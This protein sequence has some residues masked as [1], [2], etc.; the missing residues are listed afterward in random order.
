[1]GFLKSIYFSNLLG[2]KYT[3]IYPDYVGEEHHPLNHTIYGVRE[4]WRS[5]LLKAFLFRPD[6]SA[7]YSEHA[8]DGYSTIFLDDLS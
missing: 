5:S 7:L 2:F 3:E 4:L 6:F 1:M 8:Q